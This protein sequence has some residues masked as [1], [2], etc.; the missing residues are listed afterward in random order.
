MGVVC[1]FA[2]Q[3]HQKTCASWFD[4]CAFRLLWTLCNPGMHPLTPL[5][6]TK[7][8]AQGRKAKSQRCAA[9]WKRPPALAQL[10]R[11]PRRLGICCPAFS[12]PI[13]SRFLE[14]INKQPP[15]SPHSLRPDDTQS[16][17]AYT[18]GF[19]LY[20]PH[21]YYP[22]PYTTPPYYPPRFPCEPHAHYRSL[23]KT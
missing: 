12:S 4:P 18:H 17:K 11:N 14:R 1:V 19:P 22:P 8:Q 15:L 23:A 16:L 9:N 10:C 13:S 20:Y 3:E 5:Q 6:P 2:A 21:I 7:L